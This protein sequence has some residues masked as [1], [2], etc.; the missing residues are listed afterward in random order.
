MGAR[1]ALFAVLSGL[2]TSGESVVLRPGG[3]TQAVR[4]AKDAPK[5]NCRC[6][7]RN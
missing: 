6:C 1:L 4:T 3:R 2:M 7:Y 5:A